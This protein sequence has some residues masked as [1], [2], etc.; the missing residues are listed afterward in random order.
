MADIGVFRV[1]V[2]GGEGGGGGG[3]GGRGGGWGGGRV[4]E[5]GERAIGQKIKLNT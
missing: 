1:V 2:G 4:G 5:R 3:D